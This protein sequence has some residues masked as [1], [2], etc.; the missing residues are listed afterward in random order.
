M[1]TYTSTPHV[2]FHGAFTALNSGFWGHIRMWLGGVEVSTCH[3]VCIF[4]LHRLYV[5]FVYTDQEY[6]GKHAG[7]RACRR[8][9]RK[10]GAYICECC[11]Q[12]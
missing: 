7:L 12:P 6:K 2:L 4:V 3:D 1:L 5:C 9:R 11:P 10:S 8:V